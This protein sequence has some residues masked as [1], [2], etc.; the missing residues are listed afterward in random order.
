MIDFNLS[1][2]TKIYFGPDKED[3]IGDILRSENVNRVLIIVG[4]GS[5]KKNGLLTK[6][7]GKIEEKKIDYLLLE[8]VRPNPNIEF[9]RDN[10]IKIRNYK[11]DFILAIGGGS[12][13]DTAKLLAC[14]YYYDGDP[15]DFNLHKAKPTKALPV[16]VILTISAAGSEMSTSCVIQDDVKGKKAGFNS[17]LVRPVF[18]IENPKLTYSVSPYQTACGITDIMMHTLERYFQPSSENEPADGFAEA[19]LRSV[20]KAGQ[21][22][23]KNPEDYDS[24]AVLMLMSSL[25]HNGL[26]N[27][28]KP[29]GMPVHQLEHGLSGMYKTIAHGAGLAVLWPAWAKYYVQ[30]DV[31]KFD[32]YARNVWN[33]QNPDKKEN[34][35][36]GIKL[37][38]EFFRYIG[39]PSR[40]MEFKVGAIDIDGLI[41]RLTDNGT[42]VV[43]HP[44]KPLDGEVA[45]IIYNSCL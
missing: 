29:F 17:D 38:E 26:T 28:G 43:A 40:L 37:T 16:G 44:V 42:R 19:L 3:L 14:D 12:V 1:I 18:A 39:M 10:L 20:I 32:Q 30:F 35:L 36:Q 13:I 7:I 6:V 15:F 41:N 2:K 11:P 33:S 23:M 8:G 5:V 25:S 9:V 24:R 45:R 21:K 22:V 27:I 4:E 34:A 31:D